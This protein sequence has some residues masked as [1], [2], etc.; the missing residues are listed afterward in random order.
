MALLQLGFRLRFFKE[1]LGV[2]GQFY[3]VLNQHY[4][5]PDPQSD[6]APTTETMPIRRPAST[7]SRAAPSVP[8]CSRRG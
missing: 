1:R 3:N 4:Y 8:G 6:L 7:S 2:S 5:Y